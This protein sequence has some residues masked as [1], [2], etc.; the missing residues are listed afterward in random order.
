[1]EDLLSFL[2]V[3]LRQKK[4]TVNEFCG[5]IGISRQKFYR[6]VKE[7]H[8]FPAESVRS[9]ISALSLNESEVRQ[10][11]SFLD[12]RQLHKE[13]AFE[14]SDHRSPDLSYYGGQI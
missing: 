5:L 8:R 2:T 4:M 11:E 7:P 6:F 3:R 14:G 13:N 12:P 1:M 10:L 9:I